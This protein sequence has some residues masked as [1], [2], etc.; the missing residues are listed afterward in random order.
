MGAIPSSEA[1]FMVM[2]GSTM[3]DSSAKAFE[4]IPTQ[5]TEHLGGIHV[6]LV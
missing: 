3:V 2:N 6:E 1:A 5:R 4:R